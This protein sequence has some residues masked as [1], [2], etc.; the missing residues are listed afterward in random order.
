MKK[1]RRKRYRVMISLL[2]LTILGI[3]L[4][5][6]VIYS[7]EKD[8]SSSFA[9]ETGSGNAETAH[10]SEK[11]TTDFETEQ[12]QEKEADHSKT[13]E[14]TETGQNTEAA[15]QSKEET[16]ESFQEKVLVFAGD[17]YLSPYVTERYDREGIQGVLSEELL[18][19]MTNADVAVAN[20]EFPFSVRG[21][22]AEDKQFTF[23]I[24]PSY[25]KVIK[26]M[27]IDVVT[28]AN[29]HALD[30][31]IEA[32]S[33]TFD[34][35][36]QGGIAYIGAGGDKERASRPFLVQKGAETFGFLAASR[37]IPVPEWNIENRQPGMLCTYDSGALC[38]SIRQT[39]Q[40]CDFLTVYVHWG[41]ERENLPKEYQ[42][43]LAKAYIDA[44]ADLVI[45]AH[46]HVL[47]GI[48]YYNGK[49]IVYSLGNYI[50]NQEIASTMLLK[51]TV[52]QENK[53]VLQLIP[54]YAAEA[55][56]Q[57]I[58][59]DQRAEW[60]RFVEEISYGIQIGE[61]GIVQEK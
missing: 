30:Y 47:Q 1:K 41:I 53:S 18:A 52:T 16:P 40:Q 44:G 19:E 32:L 13:E 8:R 24:D 43:E 12:Q 6:W 29:N 34:T 38:E 45:G 7:G 60:Y 11:K 23:R 36:D 59:Q 46:P 15:E 58:S 51:V 56:T 33:D 27:G 37:V 31:G 10:S 55:K 20:Q 21:E 17:I 26:D 54:A 5:F 2:L 25:V 49:P 57:E 3:S 28:I 14:Q 61:D 39:R 48:E 22:P 4:C 50:F 9:V 42:R 35:L